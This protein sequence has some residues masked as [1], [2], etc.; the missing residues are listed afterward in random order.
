MPKKADKLK[1]LPVETQMLTCQLTEDEIRQHGQTLAAVLE[2]ISTEQARQTS[3]KTEM[4]ATIAGLES[5]SA[6]LSS[7]IRR[8]EELRDVQVQ[9]ELD[10]GENVYR[11]R[12]TDT[13]EIINERAIEEDERQEH[14]NLGKDQ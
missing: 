9:P 13:D 8:G 3:F 2:D 14:L 6:A 1:L 12:R 10:F 5:R 11:E 7:Q 4:K